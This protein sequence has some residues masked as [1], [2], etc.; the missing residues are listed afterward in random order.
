MQITHEAVAGYVAAVAAALEAAGH[1]TRQEVDA[2]TLEATITLPDAMAQDGGD[3]P[4]GLALLWDEGHGWDVA[5]WDAAEGRM[6][7]ETDLLLGVVPAPEVVV[8]AV[9]AVV[10]DGSP[11]AGRVVPGVAEQLAAYAGGAAPGEAGL[12]DEDGDDGEVTPE[13]LWGR[14]RQM[15]RLQRSARLDAGQHLRLAQLYAALSE[16]ED[17]AERVAALAQQAQAHAA[18]AA[19]LQDRP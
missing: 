4:V 12:D 5:L 2:D 14:L 1:S 17:D 19:V 18:I 13:V 16:V 6:N 8:R 9:E 11:R 7:L 10:A 3:G 15:D